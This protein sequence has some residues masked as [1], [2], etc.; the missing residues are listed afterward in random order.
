[1][2]PRP[3]DANGGTNSS[4]SARVTRKRSGP[5]RK[6]R[7]KQKNS[8]GQGPNGFQV[9]WDLLELR[10][11]PH[12]IQGQAVPNGISY[13]SGTPHGAGSAEGAL[14]AFPRG[15]DGR[16]HWRSREDEDS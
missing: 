6:G 2:L 3:S 4:V 14:A 16:P 9:Q 12:S 11:Q 1:M 13:D 15:A 5:F 10:C 8:T 7:G